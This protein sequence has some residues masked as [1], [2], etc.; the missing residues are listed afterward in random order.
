M[1]D[2]ALTMNT[3]P[4]LDA[5][6]TSPASA[7]PTVWA[8]LRDAESSPSAC[9]TSSRPT[10]RGVAAMNTGADNVIT[11]DSRKVPARRTDTDI[12]PDR[13]ST[14]RIAAIASAM[15]SVT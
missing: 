7:G 6:M 10:N 13:T 3:T 1:N 5:A 15:I 4:A 2:T 8:M 9:G 14:P 12:E 11:T